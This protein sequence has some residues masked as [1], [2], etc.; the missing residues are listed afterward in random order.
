MLDHSPILRHMLD[1]A[2]KAGMGLVRD[3]SELEYLQVSRKGTNDFV[4]VADT[5]SEKIIQQALQAVFPNYGL[6]M[7]EAGEIPGTAPYR[8]VVDALDG[9][10]NFMHGVPYYAT[11]IALERMH[12]D[13]TSETL[14]ALI[15][16]PTLRE[17]FFAAKGKGAFLERIGG[18]TERLRISGR[19]SMSSAL[20]VQG[21]SEMQDTRRVKV[22]TALCKASAGIRCIGSTALSLAYVAAGRYDAYIETEVKPWDFAAGALLV[23]EA[24]GQISGLDGTPQ[25][26]LKRQD[27]LAS[28]RSL[29]P[30]C[31][32]ILKEYV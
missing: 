19:S 9:T 7:E 26:M 29:H 20:I 25:T 31:V 5:R 1:A 6:L 14:A 8:W 10:V 24:G 21:T 28:N 32:E 11:A 22:R 4:T 18:K 30:A 23:R 2:R 17:I 13:G 12:T 3:F 15:H 27:V 16:A